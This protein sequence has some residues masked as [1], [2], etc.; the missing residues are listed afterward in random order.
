MKP[1]HPADTPELNEPADANGSATIRRVAEMAGVSVGTVSRV[2]NGKNKENRPAIARRSSRIRRIAQDLGYKPNTAA[3]SLS[4]GR[5]GSV[6]LMTCG[7]PGV[8]WVPVP[9]L[10]GLHDALAARGQRL[11]LA[12]VPAARFAEPEFVPHLL[13]ETTV[14]GLLVHPSPAVQVTA[15]PAFER[16]DVPWLWVNS[17]R[18]GRC[19]DPD[20]HHGGRGA[21]EFLARRDRRRI[22]YFKLSPRR[23]TG[24]HFSAARRREG[25]LAGLAARGMACHAEN[26]AAAVAPKIAATSA[27]A[28]ARWRGRGGR[29]PRRC[30]RFRRGR[31]LR[32]GRRLPAARRRRAAGRP[33]A[34][35]PGDRRLPRR[36]RS[37][38]RGRAGPHRHHPLPRRRHRGREPG[39]RPRRRPPCQRRDG[40]RPARRRGAV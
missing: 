29:L 16:Q 4:A 1:R 10:H 37:R 22:G 26:R 30:R 34:A 31:V 39:A 25:V 17:G 24:L 21:V 23:P 32:D 19:V 27:E 13:R 9:L 15:A 11:I 8:D 36:H 33:R 6:A 12:D 35:R 2:L 14:D 3:R 7:E 18:G 5:L 20:E 28:H 40:L 38:A